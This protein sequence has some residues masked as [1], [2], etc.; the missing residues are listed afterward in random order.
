MSDD[1]PPETVE[2]KMCT[3][4][5]RVKMGDSVGDIEEML[6]QHTNQ[7]DSIDYIYVVDDENILEG[8]I[9][10]KKVFST[11]DNETKVG[12][13]MKKD[14]VKVTPPTGQDRIVYLA[15]SHGL[16]AL[17]VVDDEDHLLGIV[18][19]DEILKTFNQEVKK[20][21]FRFGGL[22]HRVGEE[23]TSIT[24][25]AWVMMR[26][27]LP[28]LIVGVLGGT[29][30]ASVVTSFEELLSKFLVLAAF[31][32]VLV[33]MSDAVG[34]QSE[35]LIIRSVALDPELPLGGYIIREFKVAAMLAVVCGFLISIVAVVGWGEY[36]LGAVVGLSMLVSIIAAVCISTFLPLVFRRF[37]YDPAVATGPLATIISDITTLGIYFSVAI[38]LL[39]FLNLI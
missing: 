32:P 35:A 25:S 11:Q 24:S 14:L 36:F 8:V 16:K 20:D 29:A 4:F 30:A 1:V 3:R 9:S 33:Y 34:T 13:I 28:W 27:R 31:I 7:F 17:P 5:P 6:S 2:S 21:I 22:F 19:Y 37:N 26:S 12:N 18:P 10:I 15:L 23:Y 38:L 39:D